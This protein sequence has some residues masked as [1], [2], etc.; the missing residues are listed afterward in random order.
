MAFCSF[1]LGLLLVFL[2]ERNLKSGQETTSMDSTRKTSLF[3]SCFGNLKFVELYV[4]GLTSAAYFVYLGR[5]QE[6]TRVYP[7]N[8][9]LL[10]I[11]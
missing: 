4:A 3:T 9:F 7:K 2:F 1:A 5:F 11:A 6:K 8:W 10:K